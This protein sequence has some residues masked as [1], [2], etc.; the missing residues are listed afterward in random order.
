MRFLVHVAVL[1]TLICCGCKTQ[2]ETPDTGSSDPRPTPKLA[3][4]LPAFNLTDQAGQMFGS[5]DLKGK[6]A[7]FNF[8]FTRCPAT[9]P[10]QSM[11]LAGLQ[12]RLK[13]RPGWKNVCLVSISVDP[14]FDTPEVLSDYAERYNADLE[15]WKFLTGP[16]EAIWELSKKGFFLPVAKNSHQPGSLIMH[17]PMFILVADNGTIIGHHDSTSDDAFSDLVKQLDDMVPEQD[18]AEPAAVS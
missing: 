10:R 2:Q 14:E 17:S 9:C 13:Q 15:H 12:E 11:K 8:I 18:S 6:V 16:R 3:H 1:C 5:D 4:T 7:I